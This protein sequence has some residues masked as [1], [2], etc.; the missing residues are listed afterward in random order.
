MEKVKLFFNQ[1][2]QK[3]AAVSLGLAAAVVINRRHRVETKKPTR[4]VRR[5]KENG[6]P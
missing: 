1:H 5:K 6:T 3:I 4:P 2:W